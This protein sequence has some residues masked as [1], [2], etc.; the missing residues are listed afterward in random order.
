[1]SINWPYREVKM[2]RLTTGEVVRRLREYGITTSAGVGELVRKQELFA[3]KEKRGKREFYRFK[4]CDLE[5]YIWARQGSRKLLEM[6]FFQEIIGKV[7]LPIKNFFTNSLGCLVPV[8]P[9]GFIFAI[10]LLSYLVRKHRCDVRLVELELV[11]NRWKRDLINEK[12]LLLMD[13]ITMTG[14]TLGRIKSLLMERK[15]IKLKEIKTFVWGDFSGTADYWVY[16][17]SYEDRLNSF[18][19]NLIDG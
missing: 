4:L 1:M 10:T 13:G 18:K 5:E 12:K 16:R 17:P 6:P 7:G 3:E 15:D 8:M 14:K 2:G 19:I 9:G 11:E